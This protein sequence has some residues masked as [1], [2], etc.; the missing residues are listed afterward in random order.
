MA[1]TRL[2]L[3]NGSILGVLGLVGAALSVSSVGVALLVLQIM[4]IALSFAKSSWIRAFYGMMIL[5]M[6]QLV[7]FPAV[8]SGITIAAISLL[9]ACLLFFTSGMSTVLMYLTGTAVLNLFLAMMFS[10]VVLMKTILLFLVLNL[11]WMYALTLTVK[12]NAGNMFVL[13][14]GYKVF[15]L[16]M[17]AGSGLGGII[18]TSTLVWIIL[19]TVGFLRAAFLGW[20]TL[21]V[22]GGL[23]VTFLIAAVG[24]VGT[25]VL[26]CG[27]VVYTWLTAMLLGSRFETTEALVLFV[28]LCYMGIPMTSWS[29]LKFALLVSGQTV[30]AVVFAVYSLGSMLA[31]ASL[32][33]GVRGW[34]FCD[35]KMFSLALLVV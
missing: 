23:M 16:L 29:V 20:S 7:L 31:F 17:M 30:W 15:L 4:G 18:G 9:T 21:M 25:G 19:S 24:E 13:A 35:S 32:L 26:G 5:L 3:V 14:Q 11:F 28:F 27:L 22:T 6:S 34:L 8:T 2:L 1:L 33:V 10:T 12:L